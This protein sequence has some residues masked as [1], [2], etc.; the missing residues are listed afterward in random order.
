[1][2][3]WNSVDTKF[4]TSQL[5][6]SEFNLVKPVDY[7]KSLTILV[8]ALAVISGIISSSFADVILWLLGFPAFRFIWMEIIQQT[9]TE[10][11]S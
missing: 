4:D 1:M 11:L 9:D 3:D 2:L 6:L 7:S 5:D 8:Y 10:L